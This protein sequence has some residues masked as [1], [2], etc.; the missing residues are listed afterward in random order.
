LYFGQNLQIMHEVGYKWPI[1]Y[2][3]EDIASLLAEVDQHLEAAVRFLGAAASLR[4][5]TG[6]PVAPDQL[7]AHEHLLIDL[8]QRLGER[9]FETHWQEGQHALLDQIVA[10]VTRLRIAA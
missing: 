3:L 9:A 6:I 5:E 2:C 1:F 8:R 10:E 4:Q 7:A